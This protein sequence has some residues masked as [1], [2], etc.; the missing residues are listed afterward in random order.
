[1]VCLVAAMLMSSTSA[2]RVG[3]TLINQSIHSIDLLQWLAGPV[4][5]VCGHIATLG[6]E[7]EAEDTASAMI[8][9]GNGAMGVIQGATSC[10]PGDPARIEFR[11]TQGTIVLEEGRIKVW[12]LVDGTPEEEAALTLLE[13][14]DGQSFSDP[15]ALAYTPH[16][17]QIEDVLEAIDQDR[18]PL[19][20]GREAR[21]AIEIVRA[22]YLS[23][24]RDQRVRL[25]L[26]DPEA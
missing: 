8:I 1:M 16:Q 11:G 6:H 18:E 21:K 15:T 22:I 3:R 14:Q 7:M 26:V 25:P 4:Q 12:K 13:A 19:V 5:S 23:A 10:W 20:T 2:H 17:R 24:Q 9:Y